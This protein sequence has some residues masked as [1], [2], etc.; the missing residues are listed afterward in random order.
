MTE[1][2]QKALEIISGLPIGKGIVIFMMCVASFLLYVSKDSISSYVSTQLSQQHNVE[3][4]TPT[5]IELSDNSL[6]RINS[7]MKNMIAKNSSIDMINVYKF[8]PANDAFYQGRILVSSQARDG[9]RLD[10]SKY[11]MNWVPINAFRAQS[12]SLM[13]GKVFTS[14]VYKIYTEYVT[15][16]SVSDD[17]N[18]YINFHS[19]YDDGGK[20]LVSAPVQ[21]NAI[22][23]FVT[24]Y[25][26]STP[27][28]DTQLQEW[29]KIAR[30]TALDV[31]YYIDCKGIN[32]CRVR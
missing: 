14:D 1:L 9:S 26:T 17:Y 13:K 21:T 7:S 22:I 4:F 27:T 20:F 8:L 31:G 11:N 30:L 12:N 16:P 2:L 10:S 15:D 5:K 19:L 3:Y 23:G 28:D 32:T 25:F 29:I 18:S 6:L 24:V